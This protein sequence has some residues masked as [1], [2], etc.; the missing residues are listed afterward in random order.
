[1]PAL[2]DGQVAA[3]LARLSPMVVII[4]VSSRVGEGEP[5]LC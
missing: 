4:A 1:M 2:L 3:S 5:Y